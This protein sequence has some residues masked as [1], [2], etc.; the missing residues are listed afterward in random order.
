MP[1]VDKL[2]VGSVFMGEFGTGKVFET[3]VAV[4]LDNGVGTTE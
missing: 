2:D 4:N 3:G 1:S